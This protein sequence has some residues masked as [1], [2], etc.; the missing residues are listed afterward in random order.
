VKGDQNSRGHEHGKGRNSGKGD[1][2]PAGDNDDQHSEGED[3]HDD[4]VTH[5]VKEVAHGKKDRIDRP[6]HQAEP[7]YN[8]GYIKF[9]SG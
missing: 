8:Q 7:D 5:Q 6:D 9:V 3:A 1:I 2:D 4:A